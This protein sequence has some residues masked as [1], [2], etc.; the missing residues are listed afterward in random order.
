MFYGHVK[1]MWEGIGRNVT[2]NVDRR[3]MLTAVRA[4][5]CGE[6]MSEK[7]LS[8]TSISNTEAYGQRP[9]TNA[10]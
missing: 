5:E 6:D 4:G 9:G 8:A 7:Q 3:C 10:N 1:M 2:H